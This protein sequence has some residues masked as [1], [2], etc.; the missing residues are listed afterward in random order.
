MGYP[1]SAFRC[2]IWHQWLHPTGSCF[3]STGVGWSMD[4]I[5]RMYWGLKRRGCSMHRAVSQVLHQACTVLQVPH[6]QIPLT[7]NLRKREFI[8][9]VLVA[10]SRRHGWNYQRRAVCRYST[11]PRHTFRV[12]G[13]FLTCNSMQLGSSADQ[14][15]YAVHPPCLRWWGFVWESVRERV[16]SYHPLVWWSTTM[17]II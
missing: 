5:S 3:T 12:V 13:F 10:K 9:V 1:G 17:C 16:P 4:F 11:V 14:I 7:F 6:L 2:A 15:D 8:K